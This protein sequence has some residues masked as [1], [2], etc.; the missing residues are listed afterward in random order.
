MV[1]FDKNEPYKLI[2]RT[3]SYF[4]Y[5]DKD[6]EKVGKVNE[7][8]FIEGLV[9]FKEKRFLYYGIADSKIA[10]AMYDPAKKK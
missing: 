4:I 10:V 8:C 7:I 2:D 3:P 1:L 5:P 6:Y 9:F